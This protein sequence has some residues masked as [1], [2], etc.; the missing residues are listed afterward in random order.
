MVDILIE[1]PLI[2]LFLVAAI[3]YPLGRIQVKG[4]SL[5]VA[6]VLFTGL[7][8]GSIHPNMKLPDIVYTLGL[9]IFVYT[10]GLS[11]GATFFTSFRRDGL[12]NNLFAAAVLALGA[13][14]TV[15]TSKAYHIKGAIAAGIFA[16]S[17]TNTPALAGLLDTIKHNAAGATLDKMLA[18]PVMG[19]SVTYPIGVI[20]TILAMALMRR[21]WKVDYAAEA[22]QYSNIGVGGEALSTCPVQVTNP[23]V[24]TRTIKELLGLHGWDVVFGR[25]KRGERFLPATGKASLQLGDLVTVVGTR[26]ELDKVASQIGHTSQEH[27]EL[28]RTEFD[29]RRVFVSNPKLAGRRIRELDIENEF[30]AVITRIKRGD[31][32]MLPNPDTMLELGDRVRVVA[33]RE[34]MDAVSLFFGDSYRGVSEVDILTFSLGL[35]L[36]LFLGLVP[37]PL[38]AGVVVKLGFAG[39]P[40]IAGLAL[41]ALG[42]TG[43]MVWS[44]PYGANMTLRQIGLVL[45]LAGIG[46]RAGYGF[47]STFANGGGF[48]I[49]IAGTFITCATV[50][51][52][53][54]VGYMVLKIPFGILTGMVAGLQTQPAVLGFAQEETGSDLP[55]VGYASVYPFATIIKIILAQFL[56]T[57]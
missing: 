13:A 5:G 35:A 19:Y 52:M 22:K 25:I 53:L 9:A 37:I 15:I 39:G 38:G 40:L 21:W 30:G 54:F 44:L 47:I 34:R 42:H 16:G 4:S 2:L 12:R 6:A 33:H 1:N 14:L 7:A 43:S 57:M 28:D 26:Q 36:G 46:T 50:L 51:T 10:V 32:D 27:I 8:A 49:F 55:N 45:F 23:D 29:F 48:A 31:A 17:L 24:T 20:G 18:E 56:L 3:G 41:G 11:S